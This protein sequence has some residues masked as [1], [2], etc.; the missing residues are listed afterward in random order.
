MA[1]HKVK[2]IIESV[3]ILLL[4]YNEIENTK[5][6]I[7]S[8]YEH[9]SNFTL[10]ILD[11]HSTDGTVEY[12]KEL[13]DS[14]ENVSLDL[15]EENIGV[16]EGRNRLYYSHRTYREH[17]EI[18]YY[19]ID[20]EVVL[21]PAYI[22][23]LDND[24][25]VQHAWKEVYL[26]IMDDGYDIVGSEAWTMNRFRPYRKCVKP[27]EKFNYVGCGGMMIRHKVIYDIGLFDENF[28]PMYF[29]DPDFC[30][31]AFKVGYEIAWRPFFIRHKPHKLLKKEEGVNRSLCFQK[32]AERFKKKYHYFTPP[33]LQMPFGLGEDKQA[34]ENRFEIMDL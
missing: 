4:T 18:A 9:T 34:V 10:N 15:M 23:F 31:R 20:G 33:V 14:N 7:G 26:S 30:F 24:Q 16:V 2:K 12:L 27:T 28:S 5:K 19:K 22:M 11:N 29:E 13:A 6:C 8:L 17:G 21:S 3:E 25:F 32:S 1:K